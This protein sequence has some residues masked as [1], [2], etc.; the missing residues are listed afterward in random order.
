MA[1][2]FDTAAS[3]SSPDPL[4]RTATDS[5]LLTLVRDGVLPA[6][7][8]PA[9]W[10][11]ATTSPPA[12]VWRRFFDYT[13][14]GLGAALVLAGVIYFFA[15]NWDELGRLSRFTLLGAGV[16]I[17][18]GLAYRWGLDGLAGRLAL[19]AA[20]VLAGVLLAIQDQAYQIGTEWTLFLLWGVLI[21]PWVV[22]ARFPPLWVILFAIVNVMLGLWWTTVPSEEPDLSIPILSFGVLNGLFLTGWEVAERRL[23]WS[24]SAM[25]WVPR[26]LGLAT[27]LPLTLATVMKMFAGSILGDEPNAGLLGWLATPAGALWLIAILLFFAL[28][29]GAGR[30]FGRVAHDLFQLAVAA[31][32][33]IAIA[34]LE[35]WRWVYENV[36]DTSDDGEVAVTLL[37]IAVTLTIQAVL[38]A[39]WLRAEARRAAD[40]PA[41]GAEE[42]AP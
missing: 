24:R 13:L 1:E 8:F 40:E 26:L 5:R 42:V 15:F 37:L 35:L 12:A 41:A 16:A 38:F 7:R 18:A 23:A 14:M 30:A 19:T 20:A 33:A 29:S 4:A 28:Y 36:I 9:A 10:S 32:S 34:N 21:V 31:L 39:A 3:S 6:G 11:A 22:A 2:S 25:R 17:G 27:I